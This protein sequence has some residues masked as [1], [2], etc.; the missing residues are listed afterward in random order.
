MYVYETDIEIRGMGLTIEI[1]FSRAPLIPACGFDPPEGGDIDLLNVYV[2]R[3]V[4][5]TYE[6]RRWGMEGW[7]EDLDR[8]ATTYVYAYI[9]IGELHDFADCEDYTERLI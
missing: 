8:L 2:V 5:E 4:G 7:E 6:L 9:G 3:V 1:E